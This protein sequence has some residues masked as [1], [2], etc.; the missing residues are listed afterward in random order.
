MEILKFMNQFEY[1]DEKLVQDP[2]HIHIKEDG[3]YVLLKY[4]QL[5]SNFG[6]QI[7]RECRGSIFRFDEE[8]MEWICV[9]RPFE[10]FF[11]YGEQ[12]AAQIDWASARATAK[13]D[14]SLMKLWYDRGEWHLSTNGTIDAFKAEVQGWDFTFGDQFEK[15]VGC[16]I[17]NFARSFNKGWT[18]LF[19]LTSPETRV[20]I[21]YDLAVYFLTAFDNETGEERSANWRQMDNVYLPAVYCIEN[22][23]EVLQFVREMDKDEEGIVVRD[24]Y[25]NRIKV[26][27]EEYLAAARLV[28]NGAI[29]PK[30]IVEMIQSERIDDFLA[31]CPQYTEV[32]NEIVEKYHNLTQLLGVTYNLIA[33]GRHF[34][35]RKEMADVFLTFTFSGYLFKRYDKGVSAQDYLKGLNAEKVLQLMKGSLK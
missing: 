9:C 27:S 19:E 26:K 5:E 15:A 1:W 25:S 17:K 33:E 35:S 24:K 34:E 16:S 23:D 6:L 7:V 21:N 18:Y 2:Y 4:D 14:G 3:D 28:N 31:Y 10:K 8:K 22:L 32:V 12:Y 30:R 20:V 13:I 11:N 29:T